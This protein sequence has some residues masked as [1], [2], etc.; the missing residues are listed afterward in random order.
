MSADIALDQ[1]RY[2]LIHLAWCWNFERVQDNDS[3][4]RHFIFM[5]TKLTRNSDKETVLL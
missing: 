2:K 1:V 3:S 4:T 5:V